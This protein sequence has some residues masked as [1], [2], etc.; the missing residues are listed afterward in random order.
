MRI[1]LIQGH[2]P[3]RRCL[4]A[5]CACGVY[6]V[7][8]APRREAF[9][10]ECLGYNYTIPDDHEGGTFWC[11]PRAATVLEIREG[12]G[13]AR[14]E[15]GG[16]VLVMVTACP[17]PFG[18]GH[19]SPAPPP[20]VCRYHAHVHMS[21]SLQVSG[22]AFGLLIIDDTTEAG[23]VPV[24]EG[25][26]AASVPAI[27]AFLTSRTLEKAV[28]CGRVGMT[29]QCNGAAVATMAVQSDVWTRVRL[30][31]ADGAGTVLTLTHTCVDGSTTCCEARQIAHD[32][33]YLSSVPAAAARAWTI[34][35][36][37][38]IDLAVKCTSS[39]A[40]LWNGG[41]VQLVTVPTTGAV[42][43]S[44]FAGVSSAWA[45]ARPAYRADLT[46]AVVPNANKVRGGGSASTSTSTSTS[47]TNT[48]CDQHQYPSSKYQY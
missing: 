46:T 48:S 32:S 31:V 38:R 14:V 18:P 6:G 12:G 41:S 35:N 29:T 42:L 23:T 37:A 47:S 7:W 19:F 27:Q 22:G 28:I 40:L 36:V 45:P 1:L 21:T 3:C 9:G 15:V 13:A 16:A 2:V 11:V 4:S 24:L 43:S 17:C 39:G 20:G 30:A 8:C 25:V 26:D 44:V 5:S 10:G 33:M 34:I